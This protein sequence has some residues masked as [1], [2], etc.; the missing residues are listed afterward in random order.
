MMIYIYDEETQRMQYRFEEE[1][2]F[3]SP[4]AKEWFEKTVKWL[5]ELSPDVKKVLVNVANREYKAK[6]G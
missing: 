4:E 2:E 5:G 1:P 3:T 6:N